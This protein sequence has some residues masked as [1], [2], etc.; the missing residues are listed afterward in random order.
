MCLRMLREIWVRLRALDAM[1][2]A[3]TSALD[4]QA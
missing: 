1:E 3:V 2:F 4:L